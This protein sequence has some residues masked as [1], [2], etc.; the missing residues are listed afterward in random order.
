[1]NR[2]RAVVAGLAIALLV[3]VLL[4]YSVFTL[5]AVMDSGFSARATGIIAPLCRDT[6]DRVAFDCRA[7][8]KN[9]EIVWERKW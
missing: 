1:M 3:L 2:K 5:L 9:G 6:G 7:T 8:I 4:P